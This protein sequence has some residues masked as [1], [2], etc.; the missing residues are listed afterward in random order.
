MLQNG[1]RPKLG[2]GCGG[3]MRMQVRCGAHRR[4]RADTE[5]AGAGRTHARGCVARRHLVGA[6]C[7]LGLAS[8]PAT[9]GAAQPLPPTAEER[10]LAGRLAD[11]GLAAFEAGRDEEALDRFARAEGLVHAP[12]H[13]LYLA[14]AARRLGRMRAAKGVYQRIALEP[15]EP[16]GPAVP[17]AFARARVDATAELAALE[18]RIPRVTLQVSGAGSATANVFL[19]GVPLARPTPGDPIEI[20]P[21]EHRVAVEAGPGRSA[22]RSFVASEGDRLV[23]ELRLPAPDARPTRGWPLQRPPGTP[24]PAPRKLLLPAVLAFGAAGIATGISVVTGILAAGDAAE[25]KQ[26]CDGRNC[27]GAEGPRLDRVDILGEVA[28][29]SGAIAAGTG[30]AGGVWVFFDGPRARARGTAG[31]ARGAYTATLRVEKEF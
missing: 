18:E 25:L 19:D 22:I 29:W 24:P 11:E 3:V 27:P 21:G 20:D 15:L 16:W 13:L 14:R 23:V 30:V 7:A 17:A 10:A 12:P 31:G 9:P 8:A 1:S 4:A 5:M 2:V 28:T 26:R 6:L